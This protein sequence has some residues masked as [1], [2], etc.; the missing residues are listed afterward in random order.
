MHAEDFVR[1][2]IGQHFGEA[3]GLVVDLRPAVGGKGKLADLVRP[4]FSLELLFGLADAGQLRFGVDHTGDQVVIDLASLADHLLDAGHG[5]VLGLVGEHGAGGHVTNHPDPGGFG[6]M[7]L[8]GEHAAL[9]RGEADVLQAQA[10][11]IRSAPDGHQY[12]IRFQ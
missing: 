2:F 9:V 11:C 6:A 8:V 1:A 10:L 7:P 5:F 12:V 4:A 3:F